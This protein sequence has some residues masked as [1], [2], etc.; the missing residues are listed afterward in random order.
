M[1]V[2]RRAV[3]PQSRK[4]SGRVAAVWLRGT[5]FRV[6][7]QVALFDM[8]LAVGTLLLAGQCRWHAHTAGGTAES[9]GP[10]DC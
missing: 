9:S 8:W 3:D 6:E 2:L 10:A 4:K 7:S 1:A 5:I